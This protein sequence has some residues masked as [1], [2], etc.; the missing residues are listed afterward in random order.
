MKWTPNEL[1]TAGETNASAV[2]GGPE[3]LAPVATALAPSFAKIGDP[4]FTLHV[5][6]SGFRPDSVIL[7]NGSPEP[8][9]VVSPTELTTVVNMATAQVAMAIP[10]VVRGPLGTPVSNALTFD[11]QAAP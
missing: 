10:V 11:L 7:W 1:Y 6:G 2:R 8:T 3:S 5:T 4:T 9:T